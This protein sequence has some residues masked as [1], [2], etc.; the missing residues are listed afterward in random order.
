MRRHWRSG[1]PHPIEKLGP[2]VKTVVMGDK[3]TVPETAADRTPMSVGAVGRFTLESVL[4]SGGMGIV[5]A[6]HDPVLDRKIAVKLIR[7]SGERAEARFLREARALARLKHANVVTI[8]DAGTAA[9]SVFIAMELVDGT[10]L[11]AWLEA[12]RTWHEILR[13]FVAAGRGLAAAH[14]AGLVHRDFK[15]ENV[16]IDRGGT[17]K[18]GDFGLVGVTG[19][20]LELIAPVTASPGTTLT[21]TGSVMGTPAYMAPE[22]VR[23]ELVD[24]RADQYAFCKSLAQALDQRAKPA[25]LVRAIDRGLAER[26]SERWLS[27]S[28][29]L[30]A[31]ERTPRRRRAI[32]LAIGGA[33][34]A[35]ALGLAT[36]FAL[37]RGGPTVDCARAGESVELVWNAEARAAILGGFE[38][39]AHDTATRVTA[40]I[41]RWVGRWRAT[42]I[43][44]CR[45]TQERGDQSAEVLDRRSGCLDR[46]L[47]SLGAL[48]TNLAHPIGKAID[49]AIGAVDALPDPDAC[50][51]ARLAGSKP[52][53][54]A[55]LTAERATAEA[56][57]ALQLRAP[58]VVARA[59][60][61]L[62]AARK[63]GAPGPLARALATH[64]HV[65]VGTD[66][67]RAR[68]ELDEAQTSA[69]LARD[70]GLEAEV[71][72][73]ALRVALEHDTI[74]RFEALVPS[75]RA[76][77]ERAGSP[78]SLLLELTTV[79]T[80]SALRNHKIPEARAACTRLGEQAL[81]EDRERLAVNCRCRLALVSRDPVSVVPSCEAALTETRKHF[82]PEHPLTADALYNLVIALGRDQTPGDRVGIRIQEL[83]A[84]TAKLYGERSSE[85]AVHLRAA[86]SILTDHGKLDESRTM[87]VRA[88]AILDAIAPGDKSRASIMFEL[89]RVSTDLKDA[90]SA[91]RYAEAGRLAA[92]KDLGPD[93]VEMATIW[94]LYANAMA[95]DPTQHARVIRACA[96]AI[97]I[98]DKAPVDSPGVVAIVLLECA[99]TEAQLGNYRDA[100]PLAQRAL[101][102]F[103]GIGD[104]RLAGRDQYL[105]GHMLLHLGRRAEAETRLVDAKQRLDALG[106]DEDYV[107]MIETDLVALRKQ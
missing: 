6:A 94:V 81:P 67:A 46:G 52:S 31:L 11:R 77:V 73:I 53:D 104:P 33:G 66:A 7:S 12:S 65:I 13:T 25:W 105:I 88:L 99:S 76:A 30:D 21:R 5:F 101:P 37:G 74:D 2:R 100:L 19:D 70:P 61:A 97:A 36:V 50:T 34:G 79:E 72:F 56:A 8:H 16:F 29:L 42:R 51:A 40:G 90:P 1:L 48:A 32:A 102:I 3:A 20:E 98:A 41:D 45:A 95:T 49:N 80:R 26:P 59:D 92:E 38:L 93:N 14:A 55:S 15:P 44:A 82:G 24:E 107:P 60:L 58:D 89:A 69:A 47:V 87:L 85:M 28:T 4:G 64:A 62:A 106:G 35:V 9:G 75:T 68:A 23:G 39:G 84:L 63:L 43:D 71:L 91:V 78:P 103:E 10:N 54:P 27:M 18:V 83:G 22:Q 57:V 96:R 17:V 86:A